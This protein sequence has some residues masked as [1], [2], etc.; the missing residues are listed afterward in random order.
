MSTRTKTTTHFNKLTR[1]SKSAIQ[2]CSKPSLENYLAFLGVICNAASPL[3]DADNASLLWLW[4]ILS[5]Y[6]AIDYSANIRQNSCNAGYTFLACRKSNASSS[7]ET[8]N[9]VVEFQLNPDADDIALDNVNGYVV[10]RIVERMP[11][12]KYH[13]MEYIDS[14]MSF[15][16]TTNSKPEF[17][18]D[19]ILMAS[20]RMIDD[21]ELLN[22]L[23][24]LKSTMK[25]CPISICK[26]VKA[27]ESLTDV[28]KNDDYDFDS[29]IE[30]VFD[31]FAAL[32]L[33]GGTFGFTHNDAHLG[34]VLYDGY[35]HSLVL[36]DYGRVLFSGKMIKSFDSL[37]DQDIADQIMY[38]RLK[39]MKG[40]ICLTGKTISSACYT[41][42][43]KA[44]ETMSAVLAIP[45]LLFLCEKR[46]LDFLLKNLYLFD[47][48]CISMNLL[49]D[50]T[51]K[52]ANSNHPFFNLYD[53][54]VRLEIDDEGIQYVSVSRVEEIF[55]RLRSKR[56]VAKKHILCLGFFWFA[57]LIEY[58]HRIKPEFA[59]TYVI[60]YEEEDGGRYVVDVKA[61]ANQGVL[62][63]RMQVLSIPEPESFCQ[64]VEKNKVSIQG[65]IDL[66]MSK[67]FHFI[68]NQNTKIQSGGYRNGTSLRNLET[69]VKKV[70]KS[71]FQ[72]EYKAYIGGGES[73][74][75]SFN[76]IFRAYAPQSQAN[77]ELCILR[78]RKDSK[79]QTPSIPPKLINF[80]TN[81]RLNR[82]N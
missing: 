23:G 27:P 16:N 57:F 81:N 38:E 80:N 76:S 41:D 62:W 60:Q 11:S 3:K 67:P 74:V 33:V 26:S 15:V 71:R 49:L 25:K 82:L 13:F 2:P 64:V 6:D 42:F 43:M 65:I 47:V 19:D 58:L 70:S 8:E 46:G 35:D 37:L 55:S 48:M 18:L 79:L 75:P 77:T 31:L 51:K 63:H 50:I 78:K 32:R 54:F 21:N 30:K 28:I 1:G 10:N 73:P 12:I 14:C 72:K 29:L 36:I 52:T 20:H 4:V 22:G 53:E 44:N 45:K 34:N 7:A 66:L 24:K 9:L 40:D 5:C 68:D 59:E 17:P 39:Q 69:Y 56:R 61:L